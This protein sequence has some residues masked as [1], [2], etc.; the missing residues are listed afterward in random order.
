MASV[1]VDLTGIDS[2]PTGILWNDNVSLGVVFDANGAE[3]ILSQTGI[4]SS[5]SVSFSITD[6]NNRFTSA[7]EAS[8]RI[9]FEASDGMM[10]EVMIAN[11]DMTEPYAWTPVNSVEVIA[12]FNH[13]RGLADQDA[14]LTLTDDPANSAPTITAISANPTTVDEGGVVTLT[15]TVTD[16]DI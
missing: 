14:T 1:T 16:P 15:A 10:L 2:F 4:T 11:A 6:T 8:G 12:F 7:F 5:G 9:I 3:Q 13:I